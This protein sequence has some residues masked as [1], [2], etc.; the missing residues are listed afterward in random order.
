MVYQ[1]SQR[2]VCLLGSH[3]VSLTVPTKATFYF[4]NVLITIQLLHTVLY[5]WITHIQT[6]AKLSILLV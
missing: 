5:I 2:N 4:K 3:P 6:T 1:E